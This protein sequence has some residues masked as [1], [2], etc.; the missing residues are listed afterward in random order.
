MKGTVLYGNK[1]YTDSDLSTYRYQFIVNWDKYY[2]ETYSK[3]KEQYAQKVIASYNE[4]Y[5]N[6]KEIETFVYK[7]NNRGF[8]TKLVDKTLG[9]LYDDSA[10]KYS[11][12][13]KEELPHKAEVLSLIREYG[14]YTYNNHE[15][16]IR[17]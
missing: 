1:I 2:K 3:F 9:I 5:Y 15:F 6:R 4:Y 14:E 16:I 11:C 12:H 8:M 7:K 10:V 17:H 13:F